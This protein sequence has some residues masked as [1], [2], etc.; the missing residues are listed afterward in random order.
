M[1][2]M[3]FYVMITN[4][5]QVPGVFF[6]VDATESRYQ[7]EWQHVPPQQQF[8]QQLVM[9]HTIFW[10]LV[11]NINFSSSIDW[12][13][14]DPNWRTHIFQKGGSTTNHLFSGG[15]FLLR[16]PL[17]WCFRGRGRVWCLFAVSLTH[18]PMTRWIWG[19]EKKGRRRPESPST[20]HFAYLRVAA[21]TNGLIK[22]PSLNWAFWRP[23]LAAT[24]CSSGHCPSQAARPW[25]VDL[26]AWRM[27]GSSGSCCGDGTQSI[28]RIYPLT[29]R[30]GKS[31]FSI[32]KPSISMGHLY[33]DYVK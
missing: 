6:K 2:F 13:C 9:L 16:V 10:L 4:H 11:W 15:T 5:G 18:S 14:H 1:I 7:K 19:V 3:M 20:H 24:G 28:S 25:I 23:S 31:P 21:G 29:V 22:D 8:Q 33:H 32:G 17:F 30:H 12:E 26:L 27:T